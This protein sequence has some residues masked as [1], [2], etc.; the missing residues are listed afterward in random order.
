MKSGV[1]AL[2]RLRLQAILLLAVVFIIG[3]LVGLALDRVI[4]ARGQMRPFGG[5][6]PHHSDPPPEGVPPELARGLD[7][8]PEQERVIAAILRDSRPLTDEVLGA[9]IPRLRAISDSVRLEVR[10]VLNPKQQ[11]IFD[12]REPPLFGKDGPPPPGGRP[13]RLPG[14][15]RDSG[16]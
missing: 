5:P 6:P 12:R 4:V 16:R 7:L 11:K 8:T 2:G 13:P 15:G 14:L 1:E 3:A 10:A 9:F